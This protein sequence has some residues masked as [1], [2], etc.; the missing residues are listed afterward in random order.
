MTEKRIQEIADFFYSSNN[1][2]DVPLRLAVSI[3]P[4]SGA[5]L[6]KG[7]CIRLLSILS[8]S[9]DLKEDLCQF[10]QSIKDV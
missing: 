5:D 9:Q 8:D 1:V 10:I 4:Y 3:G 2:D 7:E 6:D